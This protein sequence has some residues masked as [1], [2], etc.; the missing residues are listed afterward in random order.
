MGNF[1]G[2]L[3]GIDTGSRIFLL[4][5]TAILFWLTS[6]LLWLLVT[7]GDPNDI[8]STK[9]LLLLQSVGTFIAPP[10][11]LVYLWS[12][13]PRVHLQLDRK[14]GLT[15]VI[16]VMLLMAIIIP[17]I[18]LLGNINQQLTLPE[19]LSG[20]ESW[21]QNTEEQAAKLAEQLLKVHTIGGLL[22]NLFLIAI[23]PALGEELF[24]RGA[25][26]RILHDWKGPIIA[27]WVAAFVFSTIHMQFYGFL[28]RFLLGA[29]FGYLLI[30]G[31]SLWL[32][33]L[34]HFTN[35]AL[36]VIFYYLKNNGVQTFDIDK[37]GTGETMWLGIVSGICGVA[38]IYFI[39]K[40]LQKPGQDKELS[41]R[42]AHLQ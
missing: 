18:N 40:L 33:I 28:P 27:I 25:L 8:N 15:A 3:S 17:F 6:A 19:S 42:D 39:K 13:N 35:N 36:A 2:L 11:L 24:F 10:A 9:V 4:V 12:T 31:K 1:K 32:P 41:R 29:Y 26:Q 7:N 14:P 20:L 5:A 34:A 30:W 22:V 38:G 16:A 37:I 21:M 23:I